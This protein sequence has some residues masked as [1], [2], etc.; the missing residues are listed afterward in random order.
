VDDSRSVFYSGD[1]TLNGLLGTGWSLEGQT[2][3]EERLKP[4]LPIDCLY[5]PKPPKTFSTVAVENSQMRKQEG[6]GRAET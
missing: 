6:P 5:V 4:K 1:T 2:P 3:G